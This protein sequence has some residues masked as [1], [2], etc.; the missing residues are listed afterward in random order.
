MEGFLYEGTA[1]LSY[2]ITKEEAE[3]TGA[4]FIYEDTLSE[5]IERRLEVYGDDIKMFINIGGASTNLGTSSYSLDF[6]PGLVMSVDKIP[7]GKERG[8]IF[9]YAAEGIPV[10][11]LLSVKKLCQMNSIAFDPVPL[12]S[13]SSSAV[14]S[15]V[16]YN[17]LHIV[18][19]LLVAM[20]IL[21]AG[22]IDSRKKR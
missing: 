18:I 22:I 13:S 4:A 12:P 16:T 1:E 8:L 9:E 14:Y 3:C 21:I 2:E 19:T 10:V 17:P 20:A 15:T 5:S 7:E 6:P 11:N